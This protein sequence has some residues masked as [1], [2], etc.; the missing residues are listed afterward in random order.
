MNKKIFESRHPLKNKNKSIADKKGPVSTLENIATNERKKTPSYQLCYSD[1]HKMNYCSEYPNV[2]F[3]KA[4]G[5]E[6]N[7]CILCSIAQ[8]KS[9]SCLGNFN[10]LPF[11][12]DQ[13]K[14][15]MSLP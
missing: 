2:G 9:E 1:S 7:L 3:K 14:T 8:H 4:R 12:C 13:C 10:K 11:Q 15:D 6:L 5:R